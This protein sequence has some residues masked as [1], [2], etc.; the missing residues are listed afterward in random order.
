VPSEFVCNMIKISDKFESSPLWREP[1]VY[2][3]AEAWLDMLL[4]ADTTGQVSFSNSVWGTRWKWQKDKVRRFFK[5]LED[6][7]VIKV[8]C[9]DSASKTRHLSICSYSDY[10]MSCVES[11]P[12]PRQQKTGTSRKTKEPTNAKGNKA[13]YIRPTYE[14][15]LEYSKTRGRED[16]ARRFFD[17]Y[18]VV[19]WVKKTG[20]PV[21]SWKQTF[22][23][24]ESRNEKPE[25]NKVEEWVAQNTI[26]QE[27]IQRKQQEDLARRSDNRKTVSVEEMSAMADMFDNQG[28]RQ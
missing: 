3:Q 7:G 14:E 24:W 15:V 2:S 5:K 27:E 16:L 23:S 12:K 9:V 13:I 21:R 20:E 10:A 26:T 19:D 11:A 22:I 8:L 17:Y 28:E 1:R 6:L 18:D 25:M 4:C